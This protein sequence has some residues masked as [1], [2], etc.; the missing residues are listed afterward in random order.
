MQAVI[1]D[2]WKSWLHFFGGAIAL[3]LPVISCAFLLYEIVEHIILG[4]CKENAVGD[5]CEFAVGLLAS[6]LVQSIYLFLAHS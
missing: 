5:I 4:E 1:F 2:D 6:S 3:W